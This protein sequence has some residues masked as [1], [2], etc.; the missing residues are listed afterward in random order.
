MRAWFQGCRAW[1]LPRRK[2]AAGVL[3]VALILLSNTLSNTARAQDDKLYEL[4]RKAQAAQQ[5]GDF[6]TAAGHYE[7]LVR[8]RPELAEVHA[9]LG[10]IYYQIHDDTKAMAALEKAIQLK[11]E[12]TAPH[13]FLGVVASRQQNY[14]K[15]IHHLETSAKLDSSNLVVPFYLGEAYFA[16]R[17]YADA[18]TAFQK[19]TSLDD[20]RADAYYYL[21]KAYG[22]L[23]KQALDRLS[24][25][26][27]GSFHMQLARARFHEGRKNWK[28]AE[29]AYDA[30]LK[31]DPEAAGLEARLQWVSRNATSGGQAGPPPPLPEK[32]ASM[33]GFLYEPPSE[34]QI[35]PLFREYGNRLHRSGPVDGDE[36]KLYR[37]AEDSQIASYLAARW[38][39]KNDPG[40]YR[41]HQLRAQLHDSRGQT[42]EAVREYRAA[43]RLKPDLQNVHFAIGSL[44]WS[45]SR[46]DEALPE[47]EAELR[48]NPNHPEALYEIADILQVRG[49]NAQAK[50]RL[51]ES[52]RQKP[53]LVEARLA[54]E[55]IYFAEGEFDKALDQMRTVV[56]L[57]PADPTPHY[58]MSM[59]Y[60]KLGKTEEARKEL[61]E[62]QR[63]QAR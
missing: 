60:R 32:E 48:I 6:Q 58:R 21:S 47:L 3:A 7:E 43:L 39:S 10:S 27:P 18:V 9:N 49:R 4:Y 8:L 15:A 17:R 30:A 28:E 36:E 31:K 37:Q 51:L 46:F 5:A 53:D 63:L 20:F 14:E 61:Q 38:I 26:H 24:G 12:L 25:E 35:D 54:I 11:P 13:L 1:I 40:S 22:E 42:D 16:T 34:Q 45:L 57:S 2:R 56:R 52:L 23:S 41:A 44:L 19:A 50:E 62:F 29:I 33:L 55:R 59:L